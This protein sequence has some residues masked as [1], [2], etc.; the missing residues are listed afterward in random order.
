MSKHGYTLVEVVITLVII[1]LVVFVGVQWANAEDNDPRTS[2]YVIGNNPSLWYGDLRPHIGTGIVLPPDTTVGDNLAAYFMDWRA[3][4]AQ[5]VM[6]AALKLLAQVPFDFDKS[7]IR[8]DGTA[9][10]DEVARL[11]EENPEITLQLGGHTDS[12]GTE[13]YNSLLGLRRAEA[14]RAA[15]VE[16]GIDASRLVA[17]SYGEE[18]PAENTSGRSS[19]NRRVEVDPR[20]S[21]P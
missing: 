12:V 14:V 13:E 6:D 4:Q 7:E 20:V 17:T 15:L 21:L 10:L 3:L 16:R 9:V 19:A 11:L 18:L 5:R 1:A 8:P 2:V